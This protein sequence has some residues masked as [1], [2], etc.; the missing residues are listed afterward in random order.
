MV[1]HRIEKDG[2]DLRITVEDAAGQTGGLLEAFQE[3]QEGR[4]SCPTDEYKKLERLEVIADGSTV[5]LR[6]TAKD[7]ESFDPREI[8]ACL[9][10]TEARVAE[11]TSKKA[12]TNGD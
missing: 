9:E 11:S 5:S 4:C 2:E 3:C 12:E 10:Y 7:G 8:E 1:K 6:L